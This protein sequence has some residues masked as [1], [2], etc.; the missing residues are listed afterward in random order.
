MLSC[1]VEMELDPQEIAKKF[2]RQEVSGFSNEKFFGSLRKDVQDIILSKAKKKR[3]YKEGPHALPI[4]KNDE[5]SDEELQCFNLDT[6]VQAELQREE[7]QV[8]VFEANADL[9]KDFLLPRWE[10]TQESYWA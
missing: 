2:W 1:E 6:H 3:F 9:E 10:E 8:Q 5:D 7:D 4:Q